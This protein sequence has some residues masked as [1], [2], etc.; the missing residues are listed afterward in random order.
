MVPA[1]RPPSSPTDS[2][3]G[4]RA[5]VDVRAARGVKTTILDDRLVKIAS[6][7][8]ELI[9]EEGEDDNLKP[10]FYNMF[11]KFRRGMM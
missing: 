8:G 10:V 6:P 1:S 3:A 11:L 2:A 9:V 4:E 5:T 7:D